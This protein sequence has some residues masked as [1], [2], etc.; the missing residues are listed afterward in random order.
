MSNLEEKK[1]KLERL[2]VLLLFVAAASTFLTFSIP[3]VYQR[4]QQMSHSFSEALQRLG[5]ANPAVRATSAV[6]LISFHGYR[7]YFGLG[8][9]I[10]V[11]NLP[12]FWGKQR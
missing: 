1:Y 12:G 3:F 8:V 2:K 9:L 5:D 10:S 4:E 7:R 6:D 11:Q